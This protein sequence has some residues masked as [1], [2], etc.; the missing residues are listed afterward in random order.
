MR[1]TQNYQIWQN[2]EMKKIRKIIKHDICK[3]TESEIKKIYQNHKLQKYGKKLNNP[4]M[5]HAKIL[6]MIKTEIKK[7]HRQKE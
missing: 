6:N 2:L 5:I 7:K 3:I 4:F 1:Y